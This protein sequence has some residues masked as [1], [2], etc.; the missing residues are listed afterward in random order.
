MS[1]IRSGIRLA[2]KRRRMITKIITTSVVDKPPINRKIEF[3][4]M[5]FTKVSK[6][7]N[8]SNK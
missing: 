1:F 5:F 6:L 2:P 8:I 3:I 4:I 7:K